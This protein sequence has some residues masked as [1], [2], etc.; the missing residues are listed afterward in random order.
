MP[1]KWVASVC[2]HQVP[3]EFMMPASVDAHGVAL[4]EL[5]EEIGKY[6]AK[7]DV[8]NVAPVPVKVSSCLLRSSYRAGCC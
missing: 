1:L 4:S 7:S 3:A 6:P 2:I 8:E 5:I